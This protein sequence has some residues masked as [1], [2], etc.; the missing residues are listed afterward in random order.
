MSPGVT[1][2]RYCNSCGARLASDNRA[3]LWASCTAAAGSLTGPP[4]VPESFWSVDLMRDALASWHI[5]R[6][7]WAYRNHPVHGTPISQTTVGGWVD[8]TQPQIS[9]LETGPPTKDLDR[10]TFWARTLR[11]PAELLWFRLRG[12]PSP[13]GPDGR[14]LPADTP[15]STASD[16]DSRQLGVTDLLAELTA[17]GLPLLDQPVPA[18][19]GIGAV[20]GLS[21]RQSADEVLRFFLQLDD[22]MGGDTLYLPLARYVARLAVNAQHDPGDGLP[23]F[24]Q[25][26]QMT[27]WLALD[28]NRH[29]EARR[30]LTTA[31]YVAHEAHEPALAASSLAY[32][33]LQETYRGHRTPALALAETALT[34]GA[35]ALTPLVETTLGTRLAR[36]HAGLGNTTQSLR[37]LEGARAA[38]A[39]AGSDEE[40]LWASYV[41]E[42]E[43]AAQEGACYLDLLLTGEAAASLRHAVE[44]LECHAPHRVRD[45]VHYLSRLAKCYLAEREVE[46]AC[47]TAD[48]A[49]T[50]SRAIG[51]ARVVERLSEF[52]EALAPF[53]E[54]R[55]AQEFRERF[56]LAVAAA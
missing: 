3:P 51:S 33:S 16:D 9:K 40:P 23:V 43:V 38:F 7:L 46:Q 29:A 21:L 30:Y 39:R 12:A 11:I 34:T 26:S 55:D 5:G 15:V 18:P 10:L 54:N 31:V 20:D 8:M 50:L 53:N 6:V 48:H 24:G 2:D 41:D 19:V 28:A 52:N 45:R 35:G 47:E 36:A 17:S 4:D 49:L 56:A 14:G 37:S 25:L 44:L 32:M 13:S 22:E 27:G 1:P 42:I